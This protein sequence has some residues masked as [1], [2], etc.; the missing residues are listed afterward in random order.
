MTMT[1]TA[2]ERFKDDLAA[3]VDGDQAILALHIDHLSEC[4]ECRDVRHDAAE[5]ASGIEEA[6]S[7]YAAPAD[8]EERVLRALE[9]E[10]PAEATPSPTPDPIPIPIPSPIPTPAPI[11]STEHDTRSENSIPL[12]FSGRVD[13]RARSA[14]A[15]NSRTRTRTRMWVIGGAAAAAVALFA[16]AKSGGGGEDEMVAVSPDGGGSWSGTIAVVDRAA[17]GAGGVEVRQNGVWTAAAADSAIPVGGGVRT[18]ASTRLELRMSDGTVVHLD[19][20]TELT[21]GEG[22]KLALAKGNLVADV[23]HLEGSRAMFATPS[24]VVEVLGTRFALTAT[25][26]LTSVRVV[27]GAIRL[28][29]DGRSV[30]V[31]A[32]EEG[33]ALK[34]RAPEVGAAGDLVGAVGWSEILAPT[35]PEDEVP[36]GIGELRAYKPG[37]KRDRDWK[38]SLARHRITVR[39]V[40]NVARTEIEET[41]QNDSDARLEGVYKFPMPADAR[42]ERLALDVDG[43]MEEGAFVAKDRA[44]KIWRGVIQKAAPKMQIARDEIIWVPGPWRDPAMLEWQQ[45]G[46]FEL[47]IFPIPARG[48]RTIQL[49]YT[50]VL[51]PQ[52]DGRRYVYPLPHRAD[53]KAPV[54]QFDVDV[55]L[56]G[57]DPDRAPRVQNYDLTQSAE[58]GA[59]RFSMSARDFQPRGDLVIDYAQPDKGAELRA[60]T[61]QGAAAAAPTL[62]AS[63]KGGADPVVVEQQK[64]IAADPRATALIA[65]RPQLPRWTES[66]QR[67][68]VVVVDSSQSMVGE[69]FA[70][71]R[72]LATALVSEMDRRDRFAI[73]ACDVDCRALADA[74]EAPSAAAA[75]RAAAWLDEVQPA[76][77]SDL[78]M[79]LE[80]AATFMDRDRSDDRDVWVLYIGDG[81]A[82]TGYR[83]PA[84]LRAEAARLA[85]RSNVAL[86]TV[87][88]GG[89]SDT[90]ALRAISRAGG[91]HFTPYTPGQRA[92]LAALAVLETTFG[93]SLERPTVVLPDGLVDVAPAELPTLRAGGELYVAARFS[94]SIKGDVILR[95]TV[96]GKSYENRF[97]I[98]LEPSTARGNAFVPRMWAAAT[99]E[100]LELEGRG[101][102]QP[103]IVAMSQAYGVLSRHTSLLVLESPAMFRAFG[104]DRARA[105]VEWTGDEE[106]ESVDASGLVDFA[107]GKDANGALASGYGRG[108][109]PA[110]KPS[111]PMAA[112][113]EAGGED[114]LLETAVEK[115]DK[116]AERREA[117]KAKKAPSP[118]TRPM[119]PPR[120]DRRGWV[121][122]RKE[123]YRVGSVATFEGVH[124]NILDAVA[125]AETSLRA[126]PNSRERH[127]ALVQALSYAG[128][129]ER[130]HQIAAAW[131]ERDRLDAEALGAMA[132]VL[133]RMGRRDDSVRTLSGVVDLAPDDRALHVRLAA[134]YDRVG[135]AE[136]ACSHRIALAA[137]APKDHG[138]L[139]DAIRC[140]RALGRTAGADR[141][142]TSIGDVELR[143]KAETSSA[144]PPAGERATGD[145]TLDARWSGSD[146]LDI[147]LVA[148]DGKRIS[149]MGGR[150]GLGAEGAGRD[151]SERLA[152]RRITAGNYIVE[153]AR[154]DPRDT[155]PVRGEVA[156]K[157][158]GQTRTLSFDLL[159][160]RA[161]VGRVAVQRRSRL[162]P[163][164]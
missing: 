22:R 118:T 49:A 74:A 132:D 106:A 83:R 153:V 121:A 113:D 129:L 163:V 155:D 152:V 45:G 93:V 32:G 143:S 25:G 50:Q 142:L 115:E 13:E 131:L 128:D 72:R 135:D 117:T 104:V 100:R 23:A 123:W 85:E 147:S 67:D 56:V 12:E 6:G 90:V 11:P 21:L 59:V 52:A 138:L 15:V 44:Q 141:L 82:S 62:A 97:P 160:T 130:A 54:G 109:M 43:K 35:E 75:K 80:R 9:A 8:M 17:E 88:I 149:W 158:L 94:G 139:G 134:A 111:S 86:S 99:I 87:G 40:G 3:V 5:A 26:D 18:D 164:R 27:R 89:D 145:L 144:I 122:M 98:A 96:G 73:L 16:V 7:D 1:I 39:I 31:R 38:L 151:G 159:D 110:A 148:P 78:T 34:G 61:F 51:D 19:H 114:M 2:C 157:V 70:R 48:A 103:R 120:D 105:A 4:D 79:A 24:G 10:A 47:R 127:R 69:R 161:V 112:M 84:D 107:A 137:L 126:E 57:A 81:V 36:A 30:D 133:G 125:K 92:E 14:S 66:R 77:A 55:R 60:W 71:A 136:R 63:K 91:G 41:F 76:G 53:R 101:E 46:R 108:P 162:V 140:Q 156:V 58:D 150:G 95:G 119:P 124:P 28:T 37:E 154:T 65:L 68:Y 146:D 116:P 42:I 64:A 102:D 29:A 33:T 20:A